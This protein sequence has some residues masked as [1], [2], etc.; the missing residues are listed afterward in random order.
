MTLHMT[1]LARGAALALAALALT[2]G[3]AQAQTAAAVPPA[4][5]ASTAAKK[6]QP[7]A[8]DAPCLKCHD[9]L[10]ED[11]VVHSGAAMGCK[12]CHGGIDASGR[13]HKLLNKV[14]SGL[15]SAPPELCMGCHDEDDFKKKTI[16]GALGKGGCLACHEA[17]SSKQQKLLKE[18]VP[19]LCVSCHKERTYFGKD[20]H[21]AVKAG[22]CLN[23]HE[24][25]ASD[26][27]GLLK[28]K[29]VQTCL[30][31]HDD[32]REAEATQDG[33]VHNNHPLGDG[34][35][36]RPMLDKLR[37][38]KPFYCASCHQPHKS[39]FPGLLRYEPKPGRSV[40]YSCHEFL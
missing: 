16:H 19:Q 35:R 24:Q 2:G 27:P 7:P 32:I 1:L 21:S 5:A 38:G 25:H 17:H 28:K 18:A 31:C 15:N 36:E 33:F 26:N 22:K 14:P 9:D 13:P 23:C 8:R 29:P 6:V 37:P 30:A 40:C 39:Q 4:T 20:L 3:W 34:V 12:A 10:F 11:P